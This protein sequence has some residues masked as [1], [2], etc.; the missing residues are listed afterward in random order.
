MSWP[1]QDAFQQDMAVGQQPDDQAFH[2]VFLT[3]DTS[4][5]FIVKRLQEGSGFP[6][7]V[8]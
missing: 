1:I 6:C 4:V 5:D 7:T 3:D 8:A 2:Q